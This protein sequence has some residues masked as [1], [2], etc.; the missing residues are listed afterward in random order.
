MPTEEEIDAEVARI[1]GMTPA[2][3]DAE[4]RAQGLDPDVEVAKVKSI[5]EIA[6]AD[7]EF[8]KWQQRQ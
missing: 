1:M 7:H 3:I 2:E 8:A 4:L 6:I 5:V